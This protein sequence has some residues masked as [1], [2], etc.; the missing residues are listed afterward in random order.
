MNTI[1]HSQ[2]NQKPPIWEVF[3]RGRQEFMRGI[4]YYTSRDPKEV[5]QNL[6]QASFSEAYPLPRLLHRERH[7]RIFV[8]SVSEK[9]LDIHLI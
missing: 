9:A 1:E 3:L 8:F 5:Y 4:L 2:N 7:L 6:Y